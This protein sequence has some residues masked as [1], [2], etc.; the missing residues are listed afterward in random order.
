[1]L[2]VSGPDLV[3]ATCLAGAIGS[4]P[5]L[6]ARGEVDEWLTRIE[7]GLASAE[8]TGEPA[9][10]ICPNLVMRSDRLREDV[11]AIARHAIEMVITS[12]GSPKPVIGP[13][14]DSG[15]LVLADV[16]TLAHAH[17]AVEAGV[18]GLILL[19]AGAGGQTGWLNPFAFVRGVR[20][21]FD[22]P[23]VIAGGMSDG[24]ALA[25]ARLLGCDLGYIG[26]RLIAAT[27][28]LANERYR[29]WLVSSSMDDVVLTKA[30]NGLW[31]SFL[32][33]SLVA[34][35]LDPDH[36]DDDVSPAAADAR[37]GH[38]GSEQVRRWTD[39]VSAGHSV[40]GIRG[41]EPAAAILGRT[42][43]EYTDA[44]AALQ[45]LSL[46]QLTTVGVDHSEG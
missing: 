17:K 20:E 14:H 13:L 27:E 28:S 3:I 35:G 24:T 10:P 30:L 43:T 41:I 46:P 32:R 2:R 19:V 11:E 22:G 29:D 4:F 38:G 42:R 9:A 23:V 33:P 31:G 25:A 44:L 7:A 21:F 16:A 40:T 15:V 45:A 8:E 36:L 6:N 18:D 26:T 37:Y 5:T 34:S 12:V 39:V 1:M